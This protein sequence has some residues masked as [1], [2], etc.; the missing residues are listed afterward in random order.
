MSFSAFSWNSGENNPIN[1]FLQKFTCKPIIIRTY[2]FSISHPN[3]F[4]RVSVQY[5]IRSQKPLY[6]NVY[7]AEISTVITSKPSGSQNFIHKLS[8]YVL[9]RLKS[10]V[11]DPDSLNPDPYAGIFGKSGFGTR[12]RF[13]MT[14]I[15]ERYKWKKISFFD[16]NFKGNY[17][18][19]SIYF[20]NLYLQSPKKGIYLFKSWNFLPCFLPS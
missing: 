16:D 17:E 2:L 20:S 9:E 5:G 6:P 15:Q 10:C 19:P 8:I 3:V 7:T 14:K 12:S 11:S 1:F 4:Q 13:L 18:R